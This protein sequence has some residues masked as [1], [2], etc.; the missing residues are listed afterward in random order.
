MNLQPFLEQVRFDA[1]GLVPVVVQ[2]AETDRVLMLAY[3]NAHT[4][5][6]TL[7]TDRMTYWSRSRQAVWVKGETSGHIQRVAAAYIDCDGD[8]LL[9]KVH[10]T[11][12]ACHTN[13]PAC[14]YRRWN[15]KHTQLEHTDPPRT[16][17]N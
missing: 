15:P 4:L 11:G 17:H 5:R 8:A 16:P 10:Q 3:M 6:L 9:F 2:D 12:P 7:E 13:R 1:Q 14:F